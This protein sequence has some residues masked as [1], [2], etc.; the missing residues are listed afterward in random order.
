MS[1]DPQSIEIVLFDYSGVMTTD[2]AVPTDDVP[3]DVDA[4]FT[5]MFG[6]MTNAHA[7]P[8]HELE[9]GEI[10]LAAFIDDV[11]S[12]VPLAGAAF[13]ADS[14]ANVMANLTLRPDRV[15]LVES[16]RAD[17]FGVGLVTNNVAEWAPL[18]RPGVGD[19][20][21][22]VVDSADVGCRKPEPEIYALS[23]GLFDASPERALFIDDFEWNV[24]GAIEAGL[25]G[26]RCTPDLDLE[27][28]VR[29]KLAE[30]RL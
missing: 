16:L 10:T 11:E 28:A 18:W 4:L 8:W 15:A 17:G 26:L 30:A 5:E 7:H 6:A 9:R 24:T 3:F 2:F 27:A 29:A 19:L 23:V 13:A 1:F 22:H 14:P 25:H 20:F 21:D 12:R